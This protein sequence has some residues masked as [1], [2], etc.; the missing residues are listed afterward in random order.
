MRDEDDQLYIYKLYGISIPRKFSAQKVLRNKIGPNG[1]ITQRQI[2]NAQDILE[3]PK[4]DFQPFALQHISELEHAIRG[5]KETSYQEGGDHNK[6]TDPLIQIKGQATMFGN[7]LATDIS[8]TVLRFIEHYKNLDDDALSI[9]QLYCNS[10]K[11]SYANKLYNGDTP[12]GR[13]LIS[14]LE[15]TIARY[16]EKFKKKTGR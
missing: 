8:Q 12:G 5:I 16:H 13:I 1:G 2:D 11:L 3:N 4:I 9:L 6:I 15:H 7:P 10:I 14:E